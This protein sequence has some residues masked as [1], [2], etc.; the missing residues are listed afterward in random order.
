[1]FENVFM[2]HDI[3]A[4]GGVESWLYYIAKKYKDKDIAVFYLTGDIKQIR[5]LREYVYVRQW[6]DGMKIKCKRA[7]YNFALLGIDDIE[8]E[9]HIYC[10]HADYMLQRIP[11]P[12][13]P[14]LNRFIAVS[15]TAQESFEKRFGIKAECFLNPLVI[16]KPQRVLKLM[17]ATRLTAEKGRERMEIL[18]RKLKEEKIPYYWIVFTTD[19]TIPTDL[20][21]RH[22]P[23]LDIQSFIADADYLVQLS[24]SEAS[25][26]SVREAIALG[27]P[28]I[29]TDLQ[30]FKE[31]GVID[32]KTG[33]ILPLDMKELDVHRIYENIPSFEKSEPKDR[34][35]SLLGK[36]KSK[37]K[38]LITEKAKGKVI[39]PYYDILLEKNM[40]I[41]DVMEGT[42]ERIEYLEDRSLV[43]MEDEDDII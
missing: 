3:N 33:Y 30:T 29:T 2:I 19:K 27:T 35:N 40:Y 37:Y 24:S 11:F 23:E 22:E 9:E 16:E 32:G 39:Q 21:M 6:K 38:R 10:I 42:R 17:S 20:F 5:R 14:K 31:A 4:I 26:Y 43:R 34:Y 13:S 28:C 36:A 18:A 12:N 8:A 41:G 25:C 7:F 1:M 15:K